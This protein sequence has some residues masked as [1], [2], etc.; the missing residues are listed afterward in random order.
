MYKHAV[1]EDYFDWSYAQHVWA[2]LNDGSKFDG[3]WAKYSAEFDPWLERY[4]KNARV[5]MDELEKMSKD[6]R[7]KIQHGYDMQLAFDEW[8]DH[9]WSPWY[10]GFSSA[11]AAAQR[12]NKPG[13]TFDDYL[14]VWGKR[15]SCRPERM[16]D[17]CGPIP[18]WRTERLIRESQAMMQKVN[19]DLD[20]WAASKTK[21]K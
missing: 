4:K 20:A 14:A 6:R 1:A 11:A 13:P 10:N 5:A 19:A 15:A 9:V 12:E 7:L 2:D 17:Q 8:F 3:E 16:L 21:A 18:D